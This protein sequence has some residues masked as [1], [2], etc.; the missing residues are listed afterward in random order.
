MKAFRRDGSINVM[1]ESPR[2]SAI[3]FKYDQ[4]ER[5]MT[6][7]RPLPSGLVFPFDWG[8]IPGTRAADGDP[9]D[10]F[11]LWDGSC[12]P[13]ILIPCRPI[14]VVNVEQTSAT[15]KRRERNDRV[16]VVPLKAPR[17][18]TL[19]SV[20]D[21]SERMR[22]EIEQFFLHSTAF[23]GKDLKLLGWEGPDTA[24]SAIRAAAS[25]P[26]SR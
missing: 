15:S 17:Q 13:G 2:G 9:L 5:A 20:F 1:V 21:L 23:E 19:K 14:G 12:Y 8:F 10:A 11:I 22:Q 26:R 16:A 24:M 25:K 7:S 4:T 6:L 3:K 18:D